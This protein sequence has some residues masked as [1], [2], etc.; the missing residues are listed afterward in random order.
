MAD[1]PVWSYDDDNDDDND[2]DCNY[3]SAFILLVYVRCIWACH[4]GSVIDLSVCYWTDIEGDFRLCLRDL[5]DLLLRKN[6]LMV[7]RI[8]GASITGKDLVQY[9]KVSDHTHCLLFD[10]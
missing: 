1:L 5:A 4:N 6:N 3:T 10:W 8:D 2:D 9:F 7:K